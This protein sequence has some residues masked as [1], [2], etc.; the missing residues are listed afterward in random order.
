MAYKDD[1]GMMLDRVKDIPNTVLDIGA[2]T[3]QFYRWAKAEWPEAFVWMVEA[4]E[5][6][7][8]KLNDLVRDNNDMCTISV[9]GDTER[10]A[11]FYTRRDKPHTEGASYYEEIAFGDLSMSIPVTLQTLDNLFD[12][13]VVF[14]LIKLDTQGSELDILTG[15]KRLCSQ[16]KYMIME[17][18]LIQLNKNAPTM[19]EVI[20]FMDSYGFDVDRVLGEHYFNNPRA[21]EEFNVDTETIIQKDLLFKNR[22]I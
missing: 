1:R 19:D 10:D 2:H 16:A 7:A 12:E 15:G 6:H 22:N 11:T 8:S 14:D 20:Q 17:I 5:L 3:G 4:N 13:S 18:S 21:A 9:L